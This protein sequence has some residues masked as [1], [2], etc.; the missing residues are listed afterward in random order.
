MVILGEIV[1]QYSKVYKNDIFQK[2]IYFHYN[3]TEHRIKEQFEELD[4]ADLSGK[5]EK[6]KEDKFE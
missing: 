3:L 2:V 4:L 5:S 1:S 6:T